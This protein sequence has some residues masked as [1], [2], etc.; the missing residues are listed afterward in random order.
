MEGGEESDGEESRMS[1][2]GTLPWKKKSFFFSLTHLC[3]P[4]HEKSSCTFVI[5]RLSAR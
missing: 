2:R 5:F 3:F 4:S 1:I